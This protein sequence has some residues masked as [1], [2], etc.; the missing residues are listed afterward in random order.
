MIDSGALPVPL[1]IMAVSALLLSAALFPSTALTKVSGIGGA[2]T[3][4]APCT[5]N[6]QEAIC[7]ATNAEDLVAIE[8]GRRI[9][10]SSAEPDALY[11]IDLQRRKIVNAAVD[12]RPQWDR[13]TYAD[14]PG[15]LPKGG[16][17]SHGIAAHEGDKRLYVVNH[18]AR[19]AVEVYAWQRR[20]ADIA[21]IGCVPVP[22]GVFANS[23]TPLPSRAFAMTN[24]GQLT[25]ETLTSITEGKDS[26]EAWTWRPR[27]G[28]SKIANSNGAGPNGLEVSRDGR[29]I[30]MVRT[31]ARDVVRIDLSGR[32]PNRVSPQLEITADNLRWT[33]DGK[34]MT[35][36][37]KLPGMKALDCLRDKNCVPPFQVIT[38]DPIDLHVVEQLE[39]TS[40]L[41]VGP[42]TVAIKVKD[43]IWLGTVRGER[44]ATMKRANDRH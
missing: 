31:G 14:C 11:I 28:W 3:S 9:I 5:R 32:T 19:E 37:I 13:K 40:D 7:K 41:V 17:F 39:G 42:P 38:L 44:L 16:L 8:G 35:T 18:G 36:G 22:A 6:R 4:A 27:A 24:M 33:P 2:L 1:R 21:W 15:P 26:G 20:S 10:A 34:L 25:P 29:F 23:I 30:Y 43:L 12:V